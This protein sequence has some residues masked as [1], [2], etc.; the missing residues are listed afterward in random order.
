MKKLLLFFVGL[1]SLISFSEDDVQTEFEKLHKEIH[2]YIFGEKL[3]ETK[4]MIENSKHNSKNYGVDEKI[5]EFF[6]RLKKLE[7]KGLAT[8]KEYEENLERV[9][10]L[11]NL[12]EKSFDRYQIIRFKTY[13]NYK[14]EPT[15]DDNVYFKVGFNKGVTKGDIQGLNATIGGNYSVK[16]NIKIGGFIHYDNKLGDLMLTTHAHIAAVG[17]NGKFKLKDNKGDIE[18]FVAYKYNY[19][20]YKNRIETTGLIEHELRNNIEK[21]YD[22]YV[23]QHSI[24]VYNKYSKEFEII[25]GLKISPQVE[26]YLSVTP[27]IKFSNFLI[28][29]NLFD[30]ISEK[31]PNQENRDRVSKP[32]LDR[33]ITSNEI[34]HVLKN[35][36]SGGILLEYTGV[37]NLNIYLN[38]KLGSNYENVGITS[39]LKVE[40]H[41]KRDVNSETNVSDK[42]FELD[43][44]DSNGVLENINVDDDLLEA[45]GIELNGNKDYIK[46]KSETKWKEYIHN[47]GIAYDVKTG[48]K[49]NFK[50]FNI[51]AYVRFDGNTNNNEKLYKD[52]H[53]FSLNTKLGY[54]W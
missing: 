8:N 50:N 51:D 33:I 20:K 26:N 2:E 31:L 37:K 9:T 17:L 43:L 24:E 54:N 44:L 13:L 47:I 19:G 16:D 32:L 30:V 36:L 39:K 4:K 15:F 14:L 12:K 49:Y 22:E 11:L 28:E 23:H 45:L 53:K 46:G 41:R 21:F 27:S 52:F 7:T 34:N 1:G 10:T 29:D 18:S 5:S 38:T 35:T 48:V 6:D 40:K 25:K 42:S 3:E